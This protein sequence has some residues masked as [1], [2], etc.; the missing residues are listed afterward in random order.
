MHTGD[1]GAPTNVT[2][3]RVT[4]RHVRALVNHNAGDTPSDVAGLHP[5]EPE[6]SSRVFAQP[7]FES[8]CVVT[9][10]VCQCSVLACVQLVCLIISSCLEVLSQRV[11]LQMFVA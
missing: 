3:Y 5:R 9:V 6:A 8:S 10:D 7:D 2:L 1:T 4:P 11:T